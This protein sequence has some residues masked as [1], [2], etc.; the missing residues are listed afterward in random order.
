MGEQRKLNRRTFLHQ[1]V[2]VIQGTTVQ[3]MEVAESGIVVQFLD[4]EGFPHTIDGVSED[5][6]S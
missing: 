1:G 6:L 5:E 3:I 2:F 4:R